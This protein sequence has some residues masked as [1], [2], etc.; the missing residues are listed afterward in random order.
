VHRLPTAAW[1]KTITLIILSYKHNI[2]C[3]PKY[4]MIQHTCKT[5]SVKVFVKL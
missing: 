3:N 4:F 1:E 2:F 5:V